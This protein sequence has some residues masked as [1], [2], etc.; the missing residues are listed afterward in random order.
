[1]GPI[2]ASRRTKWRAEEPWDMRREESRGYIRLL[3][4]RDCR[5]G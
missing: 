1:M 4:H 3:A 2:G 5:L